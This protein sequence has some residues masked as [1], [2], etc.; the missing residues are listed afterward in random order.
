MQNTPNQSHLITYHLIILMEGLKTGT[1]G[2]R[3][4]K[5]VKKFYEFGLSHQEN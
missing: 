1:A 5:M 4:E 2:S 3:I